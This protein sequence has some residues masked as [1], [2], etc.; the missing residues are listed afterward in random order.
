M[1]TKLEELDVTEDDI[2]FGTTFFEKS[3]QRLSAESGLVEP[4]IAQSKDK[5]LD[6]KESVECT[7]GDNS[8]E[9]VDVD[10]IPK[11]TTVCLD[12]ISNWGHADIVGL[13][14]VYVN[15]FFYISY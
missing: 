8:K 11:T 1:L 15:T 14:E 12:I 5:V 6:E 7:T 10:G 2:T 13:T 4:R 3:R 9:Q